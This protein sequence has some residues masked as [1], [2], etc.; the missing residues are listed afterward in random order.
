MESEAAAKLAAHWKAHGDAL[1]MRR[2]FCD[3]LERACRMTVDVAGLLRVDYS[4]NIADATVLAL[5]HELASAADVPG[6]RDAMYR[7]EHIN[8]TE[9][10]AVLHVALRAAPFLN[11]TD[12]WA[13]GLFATEAPLVNEQLAHMSDICERVH[14]G[15]WTGLS[16]KRLRHV[17]NIG[18]GGSDLGPAMATAALSHCHADA[19]MTFHFVANVDGAELAEA[20]AAVD[21]EATLFVVVSKTFTTAETM[22]N[23]ISAADALCK[24]YGDRADRRSIVA[25][26]FAAVSTNASALDAFGVRPENV[27]AF[28]D[29]VGGRYSVWSAAG[30]SLMLAIGPERFQEFLSG[31]HAVDGH[32][33][34]A[35]PTA[36][37]PLILGLLDVWYASILKLGSRAV[38]PYEHRL[39]RLPAYL[40]Q[41]DMESNGKAVRQCGSPVAW[42]TGAVVF[43]EPGTNGQ[44]AFYQLLHQGT[45][46]VPADFIVGLRPA[47]A[48]GA[49]PQ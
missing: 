19:Q 45:A 20:L 25:A 37:A 16:G 22:R 23:A 44:H 4:K 5:L 46:T 31:A 13:V 15:A 10:R 24:H 28:W 40:Q 27:A 38:L 32:F 34:S 9:D 7:G 8:F 26:H 35:P 36:N 47:A 3:D 29:W 2:M 11:T 48:T 30:L 41:A 1:D 21:L 39:A 17:L 33:A 14:G 12:D 18:I 43:G 6:R 49:D 42:P